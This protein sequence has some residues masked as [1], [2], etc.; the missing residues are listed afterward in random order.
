LRRA[1]KHP[2]PVRLLVLMK[3]VMMAVKV[4]SHHHHHLHLL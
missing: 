2:I 1:Q 4:L 3:E